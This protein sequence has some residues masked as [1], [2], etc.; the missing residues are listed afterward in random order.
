MDDVIRY[1]SAFD[2]WG[3]LDREPL[4]YKVNWHYMTKHLPQA[5]TVID[6]GAGPGKYAMDLAKRGY[7]VT[8]SDLA[9][10]LVFQAREK[11]TEM[12]LLDHFDGFYV[13]DARNLYE[14]SNE[15][16]D[17]ALMLGPLYHL[18]KEEDQVAAVRELYRVTK[19]NG[20]VFVAF[21]SRVRKLQTA[22]QFPTHWKPLD[23]AESIHEFMQTGIF[24]H[25]DEGRFTGAYFYP[26]AAIQPFM[27]ENGFETLE[28]LGSTSLGGRLT[29]ENWEYWRNR[30]EEELNQ[31]MD[32]IYEAATDPYLL[33]TSSHLLYI[34]R[35]I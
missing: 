1:Y 6:I 16:Y 8:L 29:E 18:Q 26:I 15:Q 34:G 28:L 14:I 13:Q 4:E 10:K 35:K 3:R 19:P 20:I 12:E 25:Q 24:N 23:Q 17:A 7:Q 31:V 30:G 27:E 33:G 32:M 11:A 22:L 9:A 21:M 2:E 5:G